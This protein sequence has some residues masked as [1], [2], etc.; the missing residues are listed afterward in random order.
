MLKYDRKELAKFYVGCPVE[1]SRLC[2]GSDVGHVVGFY[3]DD[4]IVGNQYVL[5]AVR[6]CWGDIDKLMPSKL[7]LLTD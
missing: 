4:S 3:V 6:D 5:I 7:Q 2:G 1:I